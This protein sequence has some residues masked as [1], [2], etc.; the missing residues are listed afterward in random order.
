MAYETTLSHRGYNLK[1]KWWSRI[2]NSFDFSKNPN[3]FFY[4]KEVQDLS[5]SREYFMNNSRIFMER[6]TIT[7]KTPDNMLGIKTDDA[8]EFDGERWFVSAISRQRVRIQQSDFTNQKS[9][10]YYWY[11]SLRK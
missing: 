8:I 6:D 11:L 9:L 4:A 7:I 10:H 2:N 1:C 3:G 5:M